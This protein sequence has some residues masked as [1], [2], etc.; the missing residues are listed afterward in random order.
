VHHKDISSLLVVIVQRFMV[1]SPGIIDL[2]IGVIA[3]KQL[4]ELFSIVLAMQDCF[5]VRTLHDTG[6]KKTH[7]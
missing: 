6:D 1:F 5:H 3:A 4:K 2:A 7:A